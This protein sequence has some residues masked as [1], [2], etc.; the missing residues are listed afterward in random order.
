MGLSA[1]IYFTI[2]SPKRFETEGEK[3]MVRHAP[4]VHMADF[5]LN[6]DTTDMI[7]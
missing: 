3:A 6:S 4:S 2:N 5:L 7:I 1:L